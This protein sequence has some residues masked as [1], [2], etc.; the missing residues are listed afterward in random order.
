ME[1]YTGLVKEGKKMEALRE[2]KGKVF[3]SALIAI[4]GVGLGVIPY[5]SVANI[6]N[7]IVEGKV[8]IATYIPYILAVL[9]GLLGSVLFHE[10]STIISHNLAYRVIE[11]KIS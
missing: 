1:K 10:F 6:I 7:N 8:E 3:A 9:V 4:I 2:H 5:F 11:E